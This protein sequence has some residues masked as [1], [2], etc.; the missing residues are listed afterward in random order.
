MGWAF[1]LSTNISLFKERDPFHEQSNVAVPL[2]TATVFLQ[3]LAYLVELDERASAFGMEWLPIMAFFLL[4]VPI[5]DLHGVESGQL[6][7]SIRPCSISG[8]EIVGDYVEGS[9]KLVSERST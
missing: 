8:R 6:S 7:I 1:L 4:Q 2:G 5:V 9:E 3:N